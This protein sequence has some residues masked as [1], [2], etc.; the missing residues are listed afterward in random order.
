MT[1]EK[2]ATTRRMMMTPEEAAARAEVSLS[3]IW[4]S[5]LPKYK[6]GRLVRFHPDDV[7]ELA[8]CRTR[9]LPIAA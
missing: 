7:E 5:G 2:D 9:R 4:R 6:V 1:T 3:T 8:R